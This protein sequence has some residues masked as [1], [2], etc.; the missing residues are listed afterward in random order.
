MTDDAPRRPRGRPP[1]GATPRQPIAFRIDRDLLAA[2]QAL[3]AERGV[4]Y[5]T[6]MHSMLEHGVRLEQRSLSKRGA[7]R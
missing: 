2:V 3:A 7:S 1:R 4:P 6:L 5:Q